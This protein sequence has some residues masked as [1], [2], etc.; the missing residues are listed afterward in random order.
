MEY[1]YDD[2]G[3]AAA[4][5][6]KEARSQFIRLTYAHLG[7]A[8]LAFIAIEAVL[9]NLPGIDDWMQAFYNTGRFAFFALLIGFMVISWIADYWARSDTSKGMQYAGL[10]LY[11]IAE[12]VIFLPMLWAADRYFPGEHVIANAAIMTLAVFGGL[13]LV[14]LVTGQDFSFLRGILVVLS[15]AALGAIIASLI[16]GFYLGLWFSF[17]MV[18]FASAVILYQ[19]SQI[20]LHYR[21]DQYVAAALGLFS[22]VALLFWYILRIFMSRR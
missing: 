19:T 10:G 15:F 12:A 7:G 11:V 1:D 13:T 4:A 16:F 14:T 2:R 5:A 8:I 3:Y 17:A 20:M 22:S 9:L 6:S 18:G 21:T